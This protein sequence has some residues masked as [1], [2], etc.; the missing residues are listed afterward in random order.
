V[1]GGADA[2]GYVT[3]IDF[4]VVVVV[5]DV[6]GEDVVRGLTTGGRVFKT[7]IIRDRLTNMPVF[8]R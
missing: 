5:V 8:N 7:V 2:S 1:Y 4:V 3:V 6:D